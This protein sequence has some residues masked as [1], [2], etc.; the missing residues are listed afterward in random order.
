MA[1]WHRC[2]VCGDLDHEC[3]QIEV[4]KG[5]LESGAHFRLIVNEPVTPDD[6]RAIGNLLHGAATKL[7][8]ESKST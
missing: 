4:A 8:A 5:K 7:E 6:L 1:W 3:D 2:S